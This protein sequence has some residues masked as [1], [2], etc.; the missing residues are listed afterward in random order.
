MYYNKN[1]EKMRIKVGLGYDIHR[2][3]NNGEF[4][5][6]AGI[7]IPYHKKFI[8]HS[9]GDVLIHAIID[10]I[11]G[12]MGEKDI[13]SHFPDDDMKYQNIDSMILLKETIKIMNGKGYEITNIDCTIVAE[14]PKINPYV[15]KMKENLSLVLNVSAEAI[16]IKAKTNEKIG[17]IGR[18]EAIKAYSIVLLRGD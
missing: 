15:D 16:S 3:E 7:K 5:V 12:A 14:E 2:L 1:S 11:L 9:D 18:G 8:A 6:L 13:G 10:S 4:I 17:E